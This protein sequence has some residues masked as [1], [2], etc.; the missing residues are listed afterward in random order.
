MRKPAVVNIIP[1]LIALIFVIILSACQPN[2]GLKPSDNITYTTEY[3]IS[4]AEKHS[5][6]CRIAAGTQNGTGPG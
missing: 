1:A 4:I 3:V 2:N 5:P 6:D